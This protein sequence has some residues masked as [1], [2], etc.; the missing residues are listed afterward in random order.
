MKLAVPGFRVEIFNTIE[1]ASYY[2]KTLQPSQQ[3]LLQFPYL[4]ANE[5]CPP[6]GMHF[7]YLVFFSEDQAVGLIPC[8]IL[9]VDF[10]NSYR[11]L[12][13]TRGLQRLL[14]N[15]IMSFK[16]RVLV[17]GN[18]SITG[19]YGFWF[20]DMPAEQQIQL[21]EEGMQRLEDQLHKEGVRMTGTFIKDY[22][23]KDRPCL[24]KHLDA[25]DYLGFDFQPAMDMPL[26][27]HWKTMEDYL[28]DLSSKYRVRYRRARK[29]ASPLKARQLSLEDVE[30][31]EATLYKLYREVADSAELNVIFL[32]EKYFS[33]L[34]RHLGDRFKVKGYYQDHELVGFCSAILSEAG[35]E[36]HYLGYTQEINQE[37]QLYLNILYSLVEMGIQSQA[38]VLHFARTAMEIKSSVGA[39]PKH[40]RAYFKFRNPLFHWFF[41]KAYSTLEP[42]PLLWQQRHPFKTAMPV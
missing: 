32:G 29:K 31:E 33:N 28:N 11:P 24:A 6:R 17:C 12:Q 5:E 21:V 4:Q 27:A 14:T 2:W 15:W 38:P 18:S 26:Q 8:Q 3:T 30:Q 1:E 16:Y 41:K 22:D 25:K 10:R 9:D 42:E 19:P 13:P 23:P 40:L 7:R 35:V 39:L 34:K 36:A 20:L 37:T